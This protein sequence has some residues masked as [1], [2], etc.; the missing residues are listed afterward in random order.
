MSKLKRKRS[1]DKHNFH[2]PQKK[3]KVIEKWKGE[4]IR[5]T[6]HNENEGECWSIFYPATND[7]LIFFKFLEKLFIEE[8]MQDTY[9]IDDKTYKYQN[10]KFLVNYSSGNCDYMQES[11]ILKTFYSQKDIDLIKLRLEYLEYVKYLEYEEEDNLDKEKYN[12]ANS[13]FK[14]L[15][16]KF[17]K[18][19]GGPT[20][21]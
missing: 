10:V 7:N 11:R 21:E 5:L 14:D 3:M 17:Y 4:F 9:V 6:E 20:P 2:P 19:E 16:S 1:C 15:E 12:K 8:D 18:C 13:K